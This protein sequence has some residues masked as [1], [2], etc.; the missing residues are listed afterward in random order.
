M[1]NPESGMCAGVS[2]PASRPRSRTWHAL[3][4]SLAVFSVIALCGKAGQQAPFQ[5]MLTGDD[6]SASSRWTGSPRN[7]NRRCSLPKPPNRP[8]RFSRSA[9]ALR[10][11]T[12]GRPS[13]PEF[14][15]RRGAGRCAAAR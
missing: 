5:R 2:R 12:T 9:V 13:T 8:V 14:G 11:K 15:P 10:A 7:G 4:L 1:S 3:A 6:A